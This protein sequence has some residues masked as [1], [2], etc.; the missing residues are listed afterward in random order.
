MIYLNPYKILTDSADNLLLLMSC[1]QGLAFRSLD[2]LFE[3]MKFYFS[4]HPF[5]EIRINRT[6][7]KNLYSNSS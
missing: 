2:L 4:F 5:A 6:C 3:R 1:L 7:V